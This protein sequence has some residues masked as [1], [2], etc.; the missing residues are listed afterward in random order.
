MVKCHNTVLIVDEAQLT[1]SI[2]RFIES[3]NAIIGHLDCLEEDTGIPSGGDPALKS[4]VEFGRFLMLTLMHSLVCH[5]VATQRPGMEFGLRYRHDTR[6][7]EGSVMLRNGVSNR[8]ITS[9]QDAA[10]PDHQF[11][12]LHPD[13]ISR[14]WHFTGV[15]H[16]VVH[17]PGT[18]WHKY[19]GNLA[20]R[21]PN[22][23]LLFRGEA[24][25][26][27]EVYFPTVGANLMGEL[28]NTYLEYRQHFEEVQMQSPIISGNIQLTYIIGWQPV[29]GW[30]Q[31]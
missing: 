1:K 4:R 15:L 3:S 16:P 27:I 6:V 19:L 10:L 24:Q 31:D 21:F 7:V 28:G 11:R 30:S 9:N 5:T 20:V 8:M 18:Q 22:Q 17:V 12:T 26:R 2:C 13:Y 23:A 25:P 29:S 14:N